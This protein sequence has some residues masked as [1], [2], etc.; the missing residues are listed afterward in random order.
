MPLLILTYVIQIAFG[1]HALRRG[2]P[3]MVIFMIVAFPFIGCAIYFFAV[4]LPEINSSRGAAK[5]KASVHD[6][7]DPNRHLRK[8]ATNLE[9][10]DTIDNK[11]KMGDELVRR[12]NP[13]EAVPLYRECLDGVYA[14]SP[15]IMFKLAEAYF[16]CEH[17][18]GA[19]DTLDALIEKN[20]DFQSQDGH[21]LY[22][23]SLEAL[24]DVDGAL[25]EYQALTE[26][27]SGPEAKCR[28]GL[29]LES[30]GRSEQAEAQFRDV[31]LGSKHAP[32]AI[33]KRHA[34]WLSVA[35]EHLRSGA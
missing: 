11:L 24:N 3:Y 1:I 25:R 20:P 9:I 17:Y 2:A 29:F 12:G 7:I 26:Y 23:R 33:R 27:F 21:L 28:Y 32:P 13:A 6:A 8:H 31:V 14:D 19:R 34:E 35:E 30:V 22:A 15:E 4:I 10:A 18:A 5:T 16:D